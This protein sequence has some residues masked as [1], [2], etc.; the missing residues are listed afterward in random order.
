M[1]NNA[2]H[3]LFHSFIFTEES[4]QFFTH[5][6]LN[7]MSSYYEVVKVCYKFVYEP[8]IQYMFYIYFSPSL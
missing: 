7:C 8:F 3:F 1:S 2:K 6:L 5:V 4:I